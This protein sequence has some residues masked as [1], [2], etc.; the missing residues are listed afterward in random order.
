MSIRIYAKKTDANQA[1]I[2]KELRDLGYSVELDHDDLLVAKDGRMVW[3]EVKNPDGRNRLQKKQKDLLENWPGPYLIAR[4]T[5]D[6]V[7][8]FELGG[9]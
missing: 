2:V 6:I 3:V 9:E 7:E 8:W 1:K 5:Q 4:S